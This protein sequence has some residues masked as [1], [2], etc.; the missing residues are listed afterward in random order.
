[1]VVRCLTTSSD[2]PKKESLRVKEAGS[3]PYL[4]LEYLKRPVVVDPQDCDLLMSKCAGM[5]APLVLVWSGRYLK[6]SLWKR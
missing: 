1:M 6:L 5:L 4:F 2:I 3:I